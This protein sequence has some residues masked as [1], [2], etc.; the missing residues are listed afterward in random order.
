MRYRSFARAIEQRLVEPNTQDRPFVL[1]SIDVARLNWYDQDYDFRRNSP[2]NRALIN[3][4]GQLLPASHLLCRRSQ[5][6]F[7]ALVDMSPNTNR[8]TI[9]Q[10]IYGLDVLPI[11]DTVR[12]SIAGGVT[13][14]ATQFPRHGADLRALIEQADRACIEAKRYE[15]RQKI[16]W[17]SPRLLKRQKRRH[18]IGIALRHAVYERQIQAHYQ[19]EVEIP[20]GR[21][22]GFEA[23]ARWHCPGYGA[24][25]AQEFIEAAE[26][27]NLIV[28]LTS[29]MLE[30]VLADLPKLKAR[31]ADATVALN[32]SPKL[33]VNALIVNIVQ[34]LSDKHQ[35]PKGLV[36][37][38]TENELPMRLSH[39]TAQ[40]RTLRGLG[41][42]IALDDFGQG[43]SSLSRLSNLPL[44]TLKIDASLVLRNREGINDKI[45]QMIVSLGR[46]LGL[47]VIAEGLETGAQQQC[48]LDAG[49]NQA[50]GW[51]YSRALPID[52]VLQLPERITPHEVS[53]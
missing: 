25:S 37:E 1:L 24:V 48:L 39:L 22:I 50:Q 11:D 2:T 7:L 41:L 34:D 28:P 47:A 6:S 42:K 21:T 29:H 23:L 13:V 35:L 49:C 43:Y 30:L 8:H 4:L 18:D 26:E 15:T 17:Y 45:I 14:G 38:I 31:F 51:Y 9:N 46:V 53:Y 27:K 5:T 16:L 32:I 36:F 33:F 52:Q 19:P 40:L 44:D 3:T 12:L 20:S 10:R